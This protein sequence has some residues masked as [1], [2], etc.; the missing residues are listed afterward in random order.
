[1]KAHCCL[2]RKAAPNRCKNVWASSAV[3]PGEVRGIAPVTESS[4]AVLLQAVCEEALGKLGW[5]VANRVKTM[6]LGDGRVCSAEQRAKKGESPFPE[7]HLQMGGFYPLKPRIIA[8]CPLP[9]LKPYFG[10]GRSLKTN[11]AGGPG[12]FD[13]GNIEIEVFSCADLKPYW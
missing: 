8:H 2:C 3:D 5:A 12:S 13:H 10:H 9:R 1:M 4:Q 7:P 11:R 6:S